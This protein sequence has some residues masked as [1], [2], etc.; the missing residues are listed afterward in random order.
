MG[1][2]SSCGVSDAEISIKGLDTSHLLTA[3]G[4]WETQG[5]RIVALVPQ[6]MPISQ[7]VAPPT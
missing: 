2:R 5:R 7:R 1:K 4:K 3:P 6:M